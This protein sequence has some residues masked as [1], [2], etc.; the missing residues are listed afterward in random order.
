MRQNDYLTI[1][2][3]SEVRDALQQIGVPGRLSDT[4][5]KAL[6][7]FVERHRCAD[8]ARSKSHPSRSIQR[9]ARAAA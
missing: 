7:E 9:D 1:R 6:I 3:T 4:V 5:R 2:C 8:G